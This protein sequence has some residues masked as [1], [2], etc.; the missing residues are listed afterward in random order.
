[1]NVNKTLRFSPEYLAELQRRSL[2][3]SLPKVEID[4][5][6]GEYVYYENH[7]WFDDLYKDNTHS[8][9]QNLSLSGSG[10]KTSFYITG[11]LLDQPGLFRYNSDDY[12]M[13]NFRAKGSIE[14]APWLTVENNTDYSNVQYHTP[15]NVGEGGGIW[16]NMAAEGP[17]MAPMFNPDGTLTHPAAYTVGDYWY[18]RNGM[19]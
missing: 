19:D 13:Y 17:P 10:E 16:R 1:Q 7:N 6:T 11:R 18:G 12:R 8:F 5:N 4:P 9:D 3:P 14:L 15:M 2:D